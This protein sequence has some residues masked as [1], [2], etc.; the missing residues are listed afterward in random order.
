M[1]ANRPTRVYVAEAN[2]LTRHGIVQ[3]LSVSEEFD[4]V[5]QDSDGRAA[6][7]AISQL[8]PDVAVVAERLPSLSG[9]EL[10]RNMTDSFG[11]RI[12][13][14]SGELDTPAVYA[15]L[16]AGAAGYLSSDT[17]G[18][19]LRAVVASVARDE[20]MLAPDVQRRLITE[21]H[22]ASGGVAPALPKREREILALLA[23]GHGAAEIAARLSIGVS[24]AKKHLSNLY[25][26]LD[27]PNSAAA[28]A[29]AL[30]LG[31]ID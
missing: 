6:A 14:V 26:K 9:F 19:R 30:R 12:V 7:H 15:A 23:D 11:T 16:A 17:D 24:T 22:A 28:V 20:P 25:H 10:L 2:G 21:I 18:E 31:V 8:E 29:T 1:A 3:A 13:V 27:A 4:V 5:G